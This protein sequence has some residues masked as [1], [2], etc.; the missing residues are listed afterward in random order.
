MKQLLLLIIS[1]L[2][3]ISCQNPLEKKYN[4]ESLF[5]DAIDIIESGK[6]KQ[7]ELTLLGSYIVEAK[8]R[9]INLIN[10]TYSQIQKKSME[11]L[12]THNE[13]SVNQ[14]EKREE[15]DNFLKDE[16]DNLVYSKSKD[17]KFIIIELF[18]ENKTDKIIISEIGSLGV[19]D[20]SLNDVKGLSALFN[21]GIKSGVKK[22]AT[23]KILCNPFD[24]ALVSMKKERIKEI[25][26]RWLPEKIIF[27]DGTKIE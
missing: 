9:G 23:I 21:N 27:E 17:N 1:P 10:F 16:T 15:L 6:L 8:L 25:K 24:M 20:L 22:K 19:P 14:F 7:N 18:F 13:P 3:L 2:Y 5:E 4:E 26:F 11:N 12:L